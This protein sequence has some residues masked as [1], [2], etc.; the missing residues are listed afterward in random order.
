MCPFHTCISH[1]RLGN[2]FHNAYD[3]VKGLSTFKYM[4]KKVIKVHTSVSKNHNLFSRD[5]Q[6]IVSDFCKNNNFS[7]QNVNDILSGSDCV[8]ISIEFAFV[9]PIFSVQPK[10]LKYL[11]TTSVNT[12]NQNLD[13]DFENLVDVIFEECKILQLKSYN[14]NLI[15]R[16]ISGLVPGLRDLI[17][18]QFD[19]DTYKIMK[20][21]ILNWLLKSHE[22][23][24][25][26]VNKKNTPI[27]YMFAKFLNKLKKY[28]NSQTFEEFLNDVKEKSK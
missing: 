22:N 26:D 20:H 28:N 9:D 4:V 15:M 27:F 18:K 23:T 21:K 6:K 1:S 5:H 3:S 10:E 2:A 16:I 13:S 17:I 14:K 11:I 24:V 19:I 8:N 25:K 12:I 7:K